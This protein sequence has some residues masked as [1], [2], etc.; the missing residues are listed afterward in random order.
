MP[1]QGSTSASC[2]PPAQ[3]RPWAR[4]RPRGGRSWP[5]WS[6]PALTTSRRSA[7]PRGCSRPRRR[8]RWCCCASG[9]P[10]RCCGR[11]CGSASATCWPPPATARPCARRCRGR[12]SWRPRCVAGSPPGPGAPGPKLPA[13][14]LERSS[15]C[16]APKAAVARPSWPPTWPSPWPRGGPRSPWS[17]S[18]CTSA[19]SRSCCSSSRPAPSRTRLA[20]VGW[21][22]ARS[23]PT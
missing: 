9:S 8:S 2:A 16:S 14:A 7:W 13:A 3:M 21:T 15:R 22:P 11:R 6:A 20:S 1:W 4:S 23:A 19:T 18:T 17:T 12:S 10:A 5:R